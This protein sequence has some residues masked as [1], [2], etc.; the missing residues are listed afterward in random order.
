MIVIDRV[1]VCVVDYS[2][3]IPSIPL[4]IDDFKKKKYIINTPSYSSTRTKLLKYGYIEKKDEF[5][6][7]IK[8][9]RKIWLK[10]IQSYG[11]DRYNKKYS[12]AELD[13]MIPY[14]AIIE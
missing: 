4:S 14:R 13:S 10:T 3:Y 12:I 8:V 6:K 11:I 2:F 9:D 1:D 5:H 7:H